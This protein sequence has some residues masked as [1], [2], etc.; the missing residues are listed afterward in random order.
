MFVYRYEI[1]ATSETRFAINL[2]FVSE[3][4]IVILFDF[5]VC[6]CY[7][8]S[9]NRPFLFKLLS[10]ICEYWSNTIEMSTLAKKK[11]SPKNRFQF[12]GKILEK[13]EQQCA[14]NESKVNMVL[15]LVRSNMNCCQCNVSLTI[16]EIY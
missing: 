10:H 14:D 5:L 8:T 4:S 16:G 9:K 13:V 12:I 11:R 2:W 7:F 15:K 6:F 1:D 3:Q